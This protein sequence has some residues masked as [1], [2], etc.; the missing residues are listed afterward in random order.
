MSEERI[1]LRCDLQ[2]QFCKLLITSELSNITI[3]E[4]VL[5]ILIGVLMVTDCHQSEISARE[6]LVAMRE[7]KEK[8]AKAIINA[9]KLPLHE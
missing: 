2:R 4:E 5:D 8:N 9:L 3:A 7:E 1:R 6:L